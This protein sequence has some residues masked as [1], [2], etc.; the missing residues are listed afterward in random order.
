MRQQQGGKRHQ[1]QAADLDQCQPGLG[2]AAGAQAVQVEQPQSQ[3]GGAGIQGAGPGRRQEGQRRH[4]GQVVAEH[5]GEQGDGT[6]GDHGIAGPAEEEGDRAAVGAVQ[7]VVVAA[8]VGV[9][10]AELGVAEGAGQR[11]C[12]AQ[13]PGQEHPAGAGAHAGHQRGRLEDAGA[14]D[15]A[16]DQGDGFAQAEQGPRLV[17]TVAAWGRRRIGQMSGQVGHA[18]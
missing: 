3:H 12:A 11:H 7:E 18:L 5:E 4:L 2:P 15:D 8:G 9:G 6:G 1:Q 10:G 16:D 17:G 13:Q 14:D